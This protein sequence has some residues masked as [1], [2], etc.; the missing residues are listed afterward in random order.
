MNVR[1]YLLKPEAE[2]THIRL[3]CHL[4]GGRLR[5]RLPL[6][7]KP[8]LWDAK[9]Q[10]PHTGK[11]EEAKAVRTALDKWAGSLP[12]W[13]SLKLAEGVDVGVD[14]A[15]VYLDTLTNRASAADTAKA[16]PLEWIA[17]YF[18]TNPE[19]SKGT[20]ASHRQAFN[21]LKAFAPGF[22]W[23]DV[24]PE[25]RKRWLTHMYGL[26][27]P[28]SANT[29]G[30]HIKCLKVWLRAAQ[31]AGEHTNGAYSGRGFTRPRATTDKI[32]L[33]AGHLDTLRAADFAAR[34]GLERI[35]DMFLI[36]CYTGLR[37][38]EYPRLNPSNRVPLQ[39][40]DG[41]TIQAFTVAQPKTGKTVIVPIAAVALELLDKYGGTVP[42]TLKAQP[43]NRHLKTA[44]K[45]AGL[46]DD[47]ERRVSV[48]D[49]VEVQR[50]PLYECVS[51]HTARRTF[52]TLASEVGVPIE[53]IQA[54]VGHATITQT[55]SYLKTTQ[56]AHAVRLAGNAAWQRMGAAAEPHKGEQ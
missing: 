35:R 41:S 27:K 33:S 28:L 36:A 21:K 1:Y 50:L 7:L 2:R 18:G 13:Y 4:P 26:P 40:E 32:A 15:R 23:A 43:F 9:R 46:T 44:C 22:T 49:A 14:D 20:K 55:L 19:Y 12:A 24:T 39:L 31:E 48:G 42:K 53:T 10:R 34:P 17:D 45:L 29:A 52:V 47:V 37:R 38:S 54:V 56:R 3:D 25:W 6:T 8:K 5:Y 30:G 11:G 51:S 16:S